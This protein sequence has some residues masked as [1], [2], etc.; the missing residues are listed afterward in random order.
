MS[1]PLK[2][3]PQAQERVK[4][5]RELAIRKL[6]E[7]GVMRVLHGVAI[8]LIVVGCIA[9]VA[10]VT[11]FG[12]F[13]SSASEVRLLQLG[14]GG[15]SLAIVGVALAVVPFFLVISQRVVTGLFGMSCLG[16]GIV[17]VP[18]FISQYTSMVGQLSLGYY[19]LLCAFAVLIF[20][21]WRRIDDEMQASLGGR[22]S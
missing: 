20:A 10:I 5:A 13:S 22:P 11:A 4:A 19:A 21:Y 17:L 12:F 9:P 7:W 1:E 18:F 3:T 8:A 6:S 14:F 2:M 15:L 16:L